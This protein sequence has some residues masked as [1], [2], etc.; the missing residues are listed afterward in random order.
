[1]SRAGW[2]YPEADILLT[3]GSGRACTL[4]KAVPRVIFAAEL[5][6][7]VHEL[8]LLAHALHLEQSAS[9][10]SLVYCTR[11]HENGSTEE[12]IMTIDYSRFRT[13]DAWD[14]AGRPATDSLPHRAN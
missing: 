7:E 8:F 1:M 3:D 13:F 11:W 14:E 12:R 10:L 9:P 4:I 5:S 6:E 2:S